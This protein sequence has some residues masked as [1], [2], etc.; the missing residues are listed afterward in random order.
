M[1]HTGLMCRAPK[2]VQG[3]RNSKKKSN[4]GLRE[5]E[6]QRRESDRPS[7]GLTLAVPP[8]PRA[9]KEEGG[10][11]SRSGLAVEGSFGPGTF[12][13]TTGRKGLDR[14][15]PPDGARLS[16]FSGGFSN[17]SRR[18]AGACHTMDPFPGLKGPHIQQN[19]GPR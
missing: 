5:E 4:K 13:R 17:L 2:L 19:T 9:M 1:L 3:P 8:A 18:Q 10:N 16:A 14:E 12:G 6:H 11:S 7:G 15:R